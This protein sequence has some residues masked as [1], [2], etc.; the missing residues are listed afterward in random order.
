MKEHKKHFSK[1]G[2]MYLLGAVLIY[3]VQAGVLAVMQK[4]KPEWFLDS[5]LS[6]IMMMIPMYLVGMP[7]MIWLIKRVPGTKVEQHAMK[8]WQFLAAVPMCFSVM[9]LSNIIGLVITYLIGL[10]KGSDVG[11]VMME[12]TTGTS[13]VV[14]FIFT[15]LC[16]PVY[17][18]YI[19]RKLIVDRTVKYGQG[20]AILLS[21]ILFGLFHG[22]LNQ[23]VYAFTL[24]LFFA[25]L[26]VKT[27]KLKYTIGIH[28]IVNFF[29]GVIGP[30][31]LEHIDL[32]AYEEAAMSGDAVA[33]L[34]FMQENM[35]GV[36]F[37]FV[38]MTIMF[39]ML[40]AGVVLFIV[41]HKKFS[42]EAGEVELPK[43]K[44]FSTIFLNLGMGLNCL[45]W[46]VVILIQL[47][48]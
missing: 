23:F 44:R 3:A 34:N 20:V 37:A 2:W 29:G 31:M 38:Y 46:I 48:E 32:D 17:E 9:Y 30:M 13:P 27:G 12:I 39:G 22:N 6:L 25:F 33:L 18:E 8:P 45:F 5:N 19:F 40:I 26:Y 41:F 14:L 43:G 7:L 16:A 10:I 36:L 42:L 21:G 47:F 24:G 1:L 28:M 11:N 35:G 4:V 15:V